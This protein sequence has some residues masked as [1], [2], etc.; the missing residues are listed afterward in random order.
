MND[1]AIIV[2]P[3]EARD[4]AAVREIC[5]D[6]ADC[7]RPMESFFPDRE[8]LA[9]LITRYY[10]DFE[11]QS[12]FVAEQAGR[13]VGYLTGCLDTARFRRVMAL[14]IV[15]PALVKAIGRGTLWHLQVRA[16]LRANIGLWL[17]GALR[18]GVPLAAYPAHLHI[19][20]RAECRGRNVGQ[21]LMTRW[22]A[23]AAGRGMHAGV[24]A[25]NEGGRRFFEAMGF[26]LLG[27]ETRMRMPGD[28]RL[29]ETL[30]YGLD[31]SAS[32]PRPCLL[33]C[34]TWLKHQVKP[35][36]GRPE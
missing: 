8:A 13:V 3:Y 23:L 31:G 35:H 15:L 4:R 22:L 25:D 26:R 30:L 24:N 1:A 36:C 20:L 18:S 21:E 32:L 10:T 33:E 11:P 34:R 27:R 14:R 16:L 2:R 19:N 9:D 29:V 12:S 28:G 5:C 6:T 17:G 7:G